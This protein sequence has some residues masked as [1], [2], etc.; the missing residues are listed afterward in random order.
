[1]VFHKGR[2]VRGTWTKNGYNATVSLKTAAG[3]LKL[4]AGHT[5][6]ELVPRNGGNVTVTK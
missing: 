1:M 3:P 5:F 6:I 4:P 2:M